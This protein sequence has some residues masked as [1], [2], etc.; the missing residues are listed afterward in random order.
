MRQIQVD[1]KTGRDLD[2]KIQ[3]GSDFW[4]WREIQVGFW[5]QTVTDPKPETIKTYD[6]S[7]INENK[8]TKKR[9]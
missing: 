2:Q 3:V 4:N 5:I 9:R 1:V 8:T 7:W 6:L